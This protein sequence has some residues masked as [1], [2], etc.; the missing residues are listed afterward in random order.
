MQNVWVIHNSKFGNSEKLSNEIATSLKE[1][2]NVKVDNIKTLNPEEIVR[3]NPYALIIGA[4]VIALN[5]DR[6]MTKFIKQLGAY[7]EEP[8]PKIATFYTHAVSWKKRFSKGMRKALKK[9][10]CIGDV[11]PEFLEVKMQAQKGPAA[12]G[13]GDKIQ[14]YIKKLIEF[15]E[16]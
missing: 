12:E 4:R 11:C 9:S 7:F 1:K 3:D 15:L 10:T 14:T 8:I 13:Q 6:K 5:T 16:E 2:F